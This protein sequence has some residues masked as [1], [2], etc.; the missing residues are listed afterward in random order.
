MTPLLI[1][2]LVS[3]VGLPLANELIALFHAG[4][5]P[6]TAAQWD[7]LKTLGAYR[8]TDALAKAGLK[9]TADGKLTP[10]P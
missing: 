2:Q 8:S 10:L 5:A 4:N 9:I 1:A 7:D 3:S 6:V